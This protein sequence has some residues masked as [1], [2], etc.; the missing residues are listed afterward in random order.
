MYFDGPRKSRPPHLNLGSAAYDPSTPSSGPLPSSTQASTMQGM[1]TTTFLAPPAH[2]SSGLTT[3]NSAKFASTFREAQGEDGTYAPVSATVPKS[4]SLP[5][6]AIDCPPQSPAFPITAAQLYGLLSGSSAVENDQFRLPSPPQSLNSAKLTDSDSESMAN[7]EATTSSSSTTNAGNFTDQQPPKILLL[8]TRPYAQYARRHISGALN[9]CIPSTLLK[10]ATYGLNRAIE[11]MSPWHRCQVDDIS[12]YDYII[13]Y[14]GHGP[15]SFMDAGLNWSG[16]SGLYYTATKF[17]NSSVVSGQLLY[18]VGGFLGFEKEYPDWTAQDSAATVANTSRSRGALP[19]LKT[20]SNVLGGFSLP[21]EST[22][23][24]P[25]KA[26]ASNIRTAMEVYDYT[27]DSVPLRLPDGIDSASVGPGG[28]KQH[29]FPQWLSRIISEANNSTTVARQFHDIEMAEKNRLQQVF[30][31]QNRPGCDLHEL[32]GVEQGTKNRYNNIWPFKHSRVLVRHTNATSPSC[33]YINANYIATSHSQHKYIATQG[34]LPTTYRDFWKV[35]WD[36]GVPVI[37]MLTPELEGGLLKCD[38]Y[39]HDADF[40][41]I[42]LRKV[43]EE[44]QTL[45]SGTGSQVRIRKFELSSSTES[46][47]VV[48]IQYT[49][50]PDLGSPASAEDIL[51]LCEMKQTIVNLYKDQHNLVQEPNALVHCSAGCGRTGTFCAVDSL[52]DYFSHLYAKGLRPQSDVVYEVVHEMRRQRIS[53][54]QNLRQYALCYE[55][56]ILWCARNGVNA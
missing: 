19:Q 40:G 52:V 29:L 42:K 11:C 21:T 27:R 17:A 16:L 26:F 14:D 20:A 28:P 33:D 18:L 55:A 5:S 4:S 22:K 53:M 47:S 13:F 44:V 37:I 31:Q 45:S 39:W 46:R 32:A 38:P 36:E 10:R 15:R 23:D 49:D 50:W 51:S 35:V 7:T 48:Q 8:D 12:S 34:P 54:V 3:P 9:M 2:Q 43:L 30:S 56:I 25:L 6:T 1:I 41:Q 24:G